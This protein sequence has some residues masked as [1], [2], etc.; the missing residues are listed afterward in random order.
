M[1]FRSLV[2]SGVYPVFS[3]LA[4]GSKG[5]LGT[6]Y[7]GT[8]KLLLMIAI[9]VAIVVAGLAGPLIRAVYG[10]GF[11]Q[12]VLPLRLL[13]CSVPFLYLGYVPVNLLVS[14]DRLTWA[15]LATGG[16]GAVN[17]AANLL[18]IP[19]YGIAGSAMAAIAAQISLFVIGAI[20]AERAVARSRWFQLVLKPIIA[21]AA[22]LIAVA[23]IG[24]TIWAVAFPAGLSIYLLMLVVTGALREEEF[25]A[26]RRLWRGAEPNRALNQ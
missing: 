21:G 26:V 4:R 24:H 19:A 14:S 17:I 25:M 5:A 2:V 20:A 6:A 9:P 8:L 7:R 10:P 16:A 23:L 11:T 15:A 3:D 18:L 13:A 1:L 22:M 12:A